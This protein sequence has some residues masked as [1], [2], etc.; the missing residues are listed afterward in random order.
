MLNLKFYAIGT[1]KWEKKT[2]KLIDDVGEEM[3]TFLFF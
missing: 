3:T 1:T 2:S